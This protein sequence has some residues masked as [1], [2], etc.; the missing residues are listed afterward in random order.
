MNARVTVGTQGIREKYAPRIQAAEISSGYNIEHLQVYGD[1][2]V[3][4]GRFYGTMK[5]RKT[6]ETRTPEGRLVLVYKH[7]K[8]TA[9]KMILNMENN[10][11]Q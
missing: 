9:W 10:G 4:S 6:G 1:V 5:D 7:D 11:S 2:A 3:V 8:N